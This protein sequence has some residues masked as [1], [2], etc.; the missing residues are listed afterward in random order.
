LD[1]VFDKK[2]EKTITVLVSEDLLSYLP[3][4]YATVFSPVIKG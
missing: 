2:K 4:S 1:C 3:Y